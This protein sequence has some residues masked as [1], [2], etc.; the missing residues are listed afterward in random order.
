MAKQSLVDL[1]AAGEELDPPISDEELIADN[2]E[3]LEPGHAP[4]IWM[5]EYRFTTAAERITLSVPQDV[6]ANLK[7]QGNASQYVAALVR[8]DV[9]GMAAAKS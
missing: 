6:A 5:I 2:Q 4:R 1:A 8:N 9:G 3:F 7:R